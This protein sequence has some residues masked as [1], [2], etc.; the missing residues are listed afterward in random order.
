MGNSLRELAKLRARPTGNR[1]PDCGCHMVRRTSKVLHPLIQAVYLVCP[2]ATCGA[3]FRGVL[4]ITHRLS[5]PSV[6]NPAISL[7]QAGQGIRTEVLRAEGL[8]PE[9][10]ADPLGDGR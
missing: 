3:T 9:N 4:E 8:L 6:P 2:S 1:C 5:P 7:P 10:A